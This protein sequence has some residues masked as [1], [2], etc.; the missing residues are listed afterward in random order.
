MP[1]VSI[2]VPVYNVEKYLSR[3]VDSIL[4]QTY[5][6]WELLLIDD[7]SPDKS[8]SICDEYAKQD[9][10]IRVFHKENGGVSSARN[11]GLDNVYGEYV[12]FVDADDWILENTLALCFSYFGKYEIIRYSMVYVKSLT[13]KHNHRF[14]LP[15]SNSRQDIFQR[16]LER[17]SLLG[18][19]GGL[20]K[21][22]LFNNAVIRFDQNLIMAEDWLVLCLLVNKCHTIIDLPNVCYCY[23]IINENSCSNNP[24]VEKVEQC[25][26][27]Q[28]CIISQ[29]NNSDLYKDSIETAKIVLFKAIIKSL[30]REKNLFAF[31]YSMKELKKKYIYPSLNSVY[32]SKISKI[33]KAVL[34]AC[35]IM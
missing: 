12:M 9:N 15:A 25:F 20:Y 1:K 6:D 30:F 19:C 34:F 2:I 21:T 32:R 3:C 7:G 22:E 13:D 17:N 10:R 33:E 14:I 4:A 26:I 24:S 23:N 8:G 29:I 27:A 31:I 18:V 11:L 28:R 16:I 35:R 5:T